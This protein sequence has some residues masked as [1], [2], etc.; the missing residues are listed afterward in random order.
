MSVGEYGLAPDLHPAGK[1]SAPAG[2]L[3]T[4]TCCAG[5]VWELWVST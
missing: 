1:G 3:V 5:D 2:A 4:G